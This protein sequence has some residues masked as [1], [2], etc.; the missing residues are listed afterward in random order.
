MFITT[1]ILHYRTKTVFLFIQTTSLLSNWGLKQNNSISD[2]NK[3]V[4]P[5]NLVFSTVHHGLNHV[6]NNTQ[7]SLALEH[8]TKQNNSIFDQNKQVKL[9]NLV[10]STVL[11]GLNH[12]NN[13]I[14]PSRSLEH[15]IFRF[16]D[17]FPTLKLEFQAE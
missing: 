6:H 3:Q 11:H 2:Q 16:T 9:S 13:K 14:M 17:N 7:S 15:S 5:S 4:K 12:V 1:K 10:F 8:Y